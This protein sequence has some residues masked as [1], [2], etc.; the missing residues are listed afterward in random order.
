MRTEENIREE[1]F[2]RVKEIYGLRKINEKFIA[3][4]TKVNYAGRVF[5]E[6]ILKQS[7]YKYINHR[8]SAYLSSW[9]IIFKASK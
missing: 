6:N 1:I 5:D 3:G 9:S 2:E 8:I 7:G 4:Q